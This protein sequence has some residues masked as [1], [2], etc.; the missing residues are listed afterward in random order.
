[1][2]YKIRTRDERF[3]RPLSFMVI[4]ANTLYGKFSSVIL[5]HALHTFTGNI[6]RG[7]KKY[8]NWLVKKQCPCLNNNRVYT[9]DEHQ[10]IK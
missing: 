6:T 8:A 2:Q 3:L 9:R 7:S 1:M 5:H 10:K 4:A